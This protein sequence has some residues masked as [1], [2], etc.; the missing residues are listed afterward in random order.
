MVCRS[1]YSSLKNTYSTPYV[2]N[3]SLSQAIYVF[4]W[5][6]DLQGFSNIYKRKTY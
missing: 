1:S 6:Q 3:F 5:N 4:S 2:E